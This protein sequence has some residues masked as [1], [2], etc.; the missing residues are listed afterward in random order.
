MEELKPKRIVGIIGGIASGKSL[1]TNMLN[2]LGAE[3]VDADEVAHGVLEE[4]SVV[5][6][7]REAFG[8]DVIV[9]DPNRQEIPDRVDRKKVAALVFGESEL[10]Q[11]RRQRLEEIVQPRIRQRLNEIIDRWQTEIESGMLALD[12]PLLYE[13]HWDRRCDEVWFV[14][15]PQSLRER[16]A[17]Q[18]GW[19]PNQLQNREKSQLSIEKKRELANRVIVNDGSVEDLRSRVQIAYEAA[20]GNPR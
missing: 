9:R 10:H 11:K 4:P 5:E 17:I 7:I 18:R 2:R 19:T 15:T 20:M 3:V 1:V 8:E 16:N 6:E 14:D 12:I 13:R